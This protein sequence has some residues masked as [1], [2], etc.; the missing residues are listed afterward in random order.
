MSGNLSV[1]EMFLNA[2]PVVQGVMVLLLLASLLCWI[3]IFEK[4]AILRRAGRTIRLF[5]KM[6][7]N[8][9]GE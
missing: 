5:K 9:N 2:D 4:A 6:A 8:I 7:G 1:T 3:I